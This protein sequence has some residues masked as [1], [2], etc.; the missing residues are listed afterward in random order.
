MSKPRTCAGCG[1]APVAWSRP[2]VD[3]C[4]RCLPGGPFTPPACSRCGSAGNYFSA[5][6]CERCHP[7]APQ[8]PGSCRDCHAWGVLRKHRWRCW[9]C[10]GWR[11][12]FPLGTCAY[13]RRQMPVNN[14]QACRLCWRQSAMIRWSHLRVTLAEANR[15]GQQLFIANLHQGHEPHRPKPPLAPAHVALT[16]LTHRQLTLFAIPRDLPAGLHGHFP[17]PPEPEIA[18]RLTAELV[19]YATSHGWSAR[20]GKKAR[21]GLRIVLGLQD[22]PGA[23]IPTTLLYQLP[24]VDLPARILHEFLDQYGLVEDD[25]TPAVDQWFAARIT[26]LPAPMTDELHRWFD[27]RWHGHD[28]H[29]RSLPRSQNTV[30]HNLR[31]ALPVLRQLALNGTQSLREVTRAEILPLLPPSGTNRVHTVTGLR[32]LFRTLKTHQVIFR[33]PTIHIRVG[34]PEQTTPLAA[35]LQTV[36]DG[37]QSADPARAVLTALLAFHALRPAQLRHLQLTDIRDG[38]IHLPDQTVLLAEPVRTRIAAYLDYRNA[39]WPNTANPHL[40]VNTRSALA[41]WP[42]GVR[43]IR[44]HLTVPA[45]DIRAD[46]ILHEVQATGGDLRKICDLFGLSIQAAQR[47]TAVL[48][49]PGLTTQQS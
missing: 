36:R 48:D 16:P 31:F 5:G 46:R 10:R 41:A 32:T 1:T 45:H 40:L 43:W 27:I 35:A 28:H 7:W 18:H 4:Y 11:T 2:R 33:D 3:Y 14:D 30:R 20:T 21:Q 37:L 24:T 23:P 13:C 44:L 25:R 19:D 6:L 38:R 17:P 39:R 42:V 26:G 49:H 47:Y 34:T 9:G 15:H 12:K 22:T 8:Y 29:P